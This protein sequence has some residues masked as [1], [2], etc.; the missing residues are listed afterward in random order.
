MNTID[1]ILL[2]S[3]VFT[4]GLVVGTTIG[5]RFEIRRRVLREMAAMKEHQK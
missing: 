2:C 5:E 3:S 4:L 1:T